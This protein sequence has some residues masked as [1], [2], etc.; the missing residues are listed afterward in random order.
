MP[1]PTTLALSV[2]ELVLGCTVSTNGVAVVEDLS[3]PVVGVLLAKYE[4][5]FGAARSRACWSWAQS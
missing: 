5:A 1:V 4:A 2:V 3:F